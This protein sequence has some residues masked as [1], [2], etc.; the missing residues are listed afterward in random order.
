[1]PPTKGEKKKEKKETAE[2][3]VGLASSHSGIDSS[4]GAKDAHLQCRVSC[5]SWKIRVASVRCSDFQEACHEAL[6]TMSWHGSA[7]PADMLHTSL[8]AN[9][10]VLWLDNPI[11]PPGSA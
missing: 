6:Y 1:M 4:I 7:W 2:R 10:V 11:H 5:H 3:F 9:S 8:L